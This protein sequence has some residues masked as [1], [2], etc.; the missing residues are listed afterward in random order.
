MEY[1][2]LKQIVPNRFYLPAGFSTHP[3]HYPGFD[4]INPGFGNVAQPYSF[5][6]PSFFQPN[7]YLKTKQIP[8][9][10]K[11]DNE[12]KIE[13]EG[14]GSENTQSDV[15]NNSKSLEKTETEEN[16]L[17]DLNSKKR[18]LLDTAIYESFTHPK[19]IKTESLL[20]TSQKN[21]K[22]DAIKDNKPSNVSQTSK[23]SKRQEQVKSVKHKFK[24]E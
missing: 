21:K 5:F 12:E 11:K 22:Y 7:P 18:K 6:V 1:S 4:C 8:T 2:L 10:P 16:V 24:F 14:K 17:D 23:Q 13:F 9:D 15:V 19:K 20:L 3:T